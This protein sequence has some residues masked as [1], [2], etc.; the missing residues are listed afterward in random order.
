L[1]LSKSIRGFLAHG[2]F[3]ECG[4]DV[5][6]E[7]GAYIADGKFIKVGNG[8]GIGINAFVQRYVHIG[9]DVMMGKDVIIITTSH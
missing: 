4:E 6:L 7:K 5:N 2:I 8:S 9:K 1:Q 3:D